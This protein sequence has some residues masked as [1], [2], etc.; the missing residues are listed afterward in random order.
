MVSGKQF[1]GHLLY[2]LSRHGIDTPH[3]VVEVALMTMVEIAPAEVEG[4]LLTVVAG[5]GELT[6]QLSLGTGNL[7]GAQGLLHDAVQLL[8]YQLAASPYIVMVAAEI[9]TPG[10]GVAIT[11]HRTLDGIDQ[12]VAFA[13]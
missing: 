12:T 11:D 13:Q 4:K 9:D 6:F 7:S 1:V 2:I 10:T 3:Q 5:N 8:P